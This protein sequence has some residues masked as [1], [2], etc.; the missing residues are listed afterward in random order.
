[1]I[2]LTRI[3]LR[4]LNHHKGRTL[5]TMLGII[6]GIASIIG[7]LSIGYGAEQKIKHK[8]LA[9]G[10]NNIEI[11][12][13]RSFI[14]N[15]VV[16]KL[17]PPKKLV[18]DDVRLL[19]YQCPEIHH[20]TPFLHLREQAYYQGKPV[21]S[22][23]K[24]GNETII[25][26]LG[27]T[28]HK[29]E[30]FS[31]YHVERSSRVAVLGA[32][33]AQALFKTNDPIGETIII[34]QIH[35]RI[36]GVLNQI[37]HYFGTQDPNLD[38]FLPYTT[39]KNQIIHLSSNQIYG[40]LAATASP[41]ELPSLVK[42]V[43]KLLRSKHNLEPEEPDDFSMTD[44]LS[45]LNA[46]QASASIFNLFLCIIASISLLVGGIGV[47]NIMLVSVTERTNEI[48]ILMAIGA[49][50][51]IIRRQFLIEAMCICTIGGIIGIL[52]GVI[53]PFF[54]QYFAGFP[55]VLK[56]QPILISFI[57]IFFVGMIFGLYPAIKASQLNP[58]DALNKQ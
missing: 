28:I 1:M 38:I 3:A 27:R 29:G 46:A 25:K 45:M 20:I 26:V 18:I 19:Q 43:R 34:K 50:S 13:G 16:T 52:L 47:M 5:L 31:S 40:I 15:A 22:H 11:W 49:S 35:V 56:L 55:I 32:K 24:G 53:A 9:M 2:I 6:L 37:E 39:L 8:I 17:A 57:T 51:R 33:A 21:I 54:A 12:A 7:T 58:V 30:M 36:V 14:D 42:R 48:G 23:L 10:N 41:D 4:S 44:Q